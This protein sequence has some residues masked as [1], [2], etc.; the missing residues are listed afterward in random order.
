MEFV[1]AGRRLR[2]RARRLVAQPPVYRRSRRVALHGH[3]L[4]RFDA[5]PE[6]HRQARRC[7]VPS[8]RAHGARLPSR[9]TPRR[10]LGARHRAGRWTRPGVGA[11]LWRQSRRWGRDQP[12]HRERRD[13]RRV[14]RLLG[15]DLRA[16]ESLVPRGRRA[17]LHPAK[18]I[19]VR[20]DPGVARRHLGGDG[21]RRL[22]ADRELA[23][24]DRGLRRIPRPPHRQRI[25]HH[26]AVGLRWSATRVARAGGLRG[27]RPR[28]GAASRD[29]ALRPRGDVS[30][31]K[32]AVHDQRGRAV[33]ARSRRDLG[34]SILYAPGID[35]SH[36]TED[37]IEMQRTGTS[38]DGLPPAHPCARSRALS[39]DI[40]AGR[41][42]DDRRPAVLL[43]HDA[44]R[45]SVRRGVRPLDAVRQRA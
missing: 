31:E 41:R 40:P 32:N 30:P 42:A 21:S 25:P 4:G 44:P 45:Q 29:R 19:Q 8:I 10:I 35:A 22:H 34:F 12:D 24:H 9:R 16:S 43:P 5:H 7:G 15:R 38:A 1:L 28:R 39:R 23:L 27:A 26:H 36:A 17:Q 3:R 18:L 6:R 14:S 33:C 13:A 2:P 20:R 37:P 11:R